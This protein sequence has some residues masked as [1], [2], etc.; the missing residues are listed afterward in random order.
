M[1]KQSLFS[2]VAFPAEISWPW[3]AYSLRLPFSVHENTVQRKCFPIYDRKH[4]SILQTSSE[5]QFIVSRQHG[6]YTFLTKPHPNLVILPRELK[7]RGNGIKKFMIT[8][9]YHSSHLF[10]QLQIWQVQLHSS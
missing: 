1:V 3:T 4:D 2:M 10:L 5:T 7:H 6:L 9:W 8:S